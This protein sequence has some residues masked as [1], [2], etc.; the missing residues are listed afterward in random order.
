MHLAWSILL[1]LCISVDSGAR[2]STAGLKV[3][4]YNIWNGFDWGKDDERR[5]ALGSWLAAQN[6]DVV[7]LQELCGYTDDKLQ[8][9]ALQWGHQ[10]SILLKTTGYPVGLASNRPIELVEK[11]LI[12]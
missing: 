11:L 7:A 12:Y 1:I 9:D 3:I 10:Y 6:P 5:I 2:E 4:T 8:Q